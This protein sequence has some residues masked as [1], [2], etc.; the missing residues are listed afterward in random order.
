MAQDNQWRHRARRRRKVV[1]FRRVVECVCGVPILSRE[2]DRAR[3]TEVAR[4]DVR[5]RRSLDH[6]LRTCVEV[7]HQHTFG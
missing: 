1:V 6:I 4:V 5:R 3:D 7:E 2:L